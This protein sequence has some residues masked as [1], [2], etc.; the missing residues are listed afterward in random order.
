MAARKRLQFNFEIKPIS[1]VA[2]MKD[3][4]NMIFPFAWIEERASLPVALA[5][6]VDVVAL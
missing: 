4:R 6:A 1:Q 5:V 3:L 2:V